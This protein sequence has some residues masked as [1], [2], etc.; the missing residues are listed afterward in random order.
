LIG[1]QALTVD[2]PFAL[3]RIDRPFAT[4]ITAYR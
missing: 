2:D 3:R 4:V 1:M